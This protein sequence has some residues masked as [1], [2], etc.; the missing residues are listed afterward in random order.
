MAANGYRLAMFSPAGGVLPDLTEYA[1]W[2]LAYSD[3]NV[4]VCVVTI[5]GTERKLTDWITGSW[6]E[7]WRSVNGITYLEGDRHWRLLDIRSYRDADGAYLHELWFFDPLLWLKAR[8]VLYAAG[9]AQAEMTDQADDMLKAV[10]K[11][12][13]GSDAVAGRD[14]SAY[15]T[16]D[17]DLSRGASITKGFAWREV[18]TTLREI[19]QQNEQAGGGW[20][21]FD[22]VRTGANTDAFRTYTGHR[23]T[24]RTSEPAISWERGNLREPSITISNY[25]AP[26]HITA[27]GRGEET[28]RVTAEA[29]LANL[30]PR[31]RWEGFIDARNT[32]TD[33]S[34][35]AELTALALAE[36]NA[37]LNRVQPRVYFTGS[38]AETENYR[39]GI[40]V[41]YGDLVK[42]EFDGY[43]FEARVNAVMITMDSAGAETLTVRMEATA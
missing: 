43:T 9:T 3:K 19:C 37:E 5:A 20:L 39:W 12:N 27:A 10:V 38:I 35:T 40:N 13:L 21:T 17:A 30:T 16:I 24:D 8:H 14:L 26:N 25:D 34:T 6:L 22:L 36:A 31:T 28:A 2:S 32:G 42:V 29:Y 23:G 4:G 18:L 11:D 7:V 33:A 1:G 15:V 41:N